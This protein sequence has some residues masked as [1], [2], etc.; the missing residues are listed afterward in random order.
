MTIGAISLKIRDMKKSFE[1]NP[2]LYERTA[3]ERIKEII[4]D[5]LDVYDD[6]VN[7]YT[8]LI[9]D[10]GADSLDLVEIAMNC[11]QEFGISIPD[12]KWLSGGKKVS[13]VINVIKSYNNGII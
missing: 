8:D 1:Y 12:E 4:I 5:V 10:L 13:D 6:K 3:Y 11:E 9:E 2:N 7:E